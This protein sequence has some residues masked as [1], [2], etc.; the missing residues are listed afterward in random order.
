[1]NIYVG[2]ISWGLE[3][4]DLE[5]GPFKRFWFRRNE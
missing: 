2:N 3:D 4:Q 5:E 1:M